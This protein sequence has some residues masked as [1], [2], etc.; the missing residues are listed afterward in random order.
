[1]S[2]LKKICSVILLV[3]LFALAGCPEMAQ[4]GGSSSGESRG[5]SQD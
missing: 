3:S 2:I 1:M 4:Q 5:S